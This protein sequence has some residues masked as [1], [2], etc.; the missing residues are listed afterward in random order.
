MPL[1]KNCIIYHIYFYIFSEDIFTFDNV[2]MKCSFRNTQNGRPE[3]IQ[4]KAEYKKLCFLL[5]LYF[6]LPYASHSM[7]VSA[8]SVRFN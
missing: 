2:I 3:A 5:L 7:K 8:V 6:T 4:E 1:N